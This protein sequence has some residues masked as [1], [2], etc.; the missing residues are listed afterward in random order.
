VPY[1]KSIARKEFQQTTEALRVQVRHSSLKKSSIPHDIEQCVY[2]NAIFQTS[3]AIEEYIK[4]LLE[5]WIHLLHSNSKSLNE[6]PKE[7]ISWSVGK[8]QLRA[9]QD[10]IVFGDEGKFIDKISAMNNIRNYFNSATMVRDVIS[11]PEHVRDRKYPSKKNISLLFRRFG[12]SDIFNKVNIRGR[13]NYKIILESF[14]DVRTA[15]A[16]E[17]PTPDLTAH[18][19]IN[20]IALINDFIGKVDMVMYSH[21]VSTSGLDCWKVSRL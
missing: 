2:R 8:K 7:L 5:D 13:N 11:Q 1:T 3:A 16:H 18:D 14:S 10:F 9:Y 12:I 4:Y 6:V 17:H 19:V 21:V 15:I 20:Q